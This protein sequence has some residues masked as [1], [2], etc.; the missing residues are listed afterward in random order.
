MYSFL[1]WLL[2]AAVGIAAVVFTLVNRMS[3]DLNLWPIPYLVTAPLWLVVLLAGFGGFVIGGCVAWLSGG[4]TRAKLRAARR[5]AESVERDLFY[6][7]R[8]AKKLEEDLKA[9]EQPAPAAV[10]EAQ[11]DAPPALPAAEKTGT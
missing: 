1:A 7:Q 11:A 4:E 8:K 10:L 6:E 2:M 5:R 9:A 3:L